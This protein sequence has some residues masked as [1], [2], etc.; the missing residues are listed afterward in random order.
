[1]GPSSILTAGECV[2]SATAHKC[3]GDCNLHT[4]MCSLNAVEIYLDLILAFV[5]SPGKAT[6]LQLGTIS[7]WSVAK[8]IDHID[9]GLQ[10]HIDSVTQ[11][12]ATW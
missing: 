8:N 9:R 1:M 6:S 12:A 5:K 10:G 11:R 7:D 3:N 2:D 4:E